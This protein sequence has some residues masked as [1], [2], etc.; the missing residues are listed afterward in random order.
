MIDLSPL[1][2]LALVKAAFWILFM[3]ALAR[4]AIVARKSE[5]IIDVYS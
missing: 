3:S 4:K 5:A 2:L 1:V